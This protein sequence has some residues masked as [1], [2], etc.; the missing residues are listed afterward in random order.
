MSVHPR[1]TPSAPEGSPDSHPRWSPKPFI[2]PN[3]SVSRSP[4]PML[5]TLAN[6]GY[7]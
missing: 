4:C 3:D 5:N 1:N 2:A 6:H 7:L